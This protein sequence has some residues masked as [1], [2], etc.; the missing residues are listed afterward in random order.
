MVNLRLNGNIGPARMTIGSRNVLSANITPMKMRTGASETRNRM[1]E[2]WIKLREAAAMLQVT[3]W[4][5]KKME[6]EGLLQGRKLGSGNSHREISRES[7]VR[8]LCAEK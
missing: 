3:V 5:I 1:N 8:L 2:Q 6:A 4:K 7:V